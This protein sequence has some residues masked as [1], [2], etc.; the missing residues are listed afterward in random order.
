MGLNI[1]LE[2]TAWEELGRELS[3]QFPK[4]IVSG[5]FKRIL[6]IQA[7]KLQKPLKNKTPVF[8]GNLKKSVK[9]KGDRYRNGNVYAMV[10]YQYAL[11]AQH[12]FFVTMGTKNRSTKSGANRGRHPKAKPDIFPSLERENRSMIEN[13]VSASIADS[14]NRSA[15]KMD[16]KYGNA[17]R[18]R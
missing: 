1:N 10:G 7:R 5:E 8:T 3:S 9:A 2:T 14:V 16:K 4:K 11:K 17:W 6:M 12:Q 18:K 13:N 15:I